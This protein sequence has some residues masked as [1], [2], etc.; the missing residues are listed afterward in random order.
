MK[1]VGTLGDLTSR[2]VTTDQQRPLAADPAVAANSESGSAG[3][4][5]CGTAP[6]FQHAM[7]AWIHSIEFGSAIVT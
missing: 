6:S 1:P 3:G 5:G 4:S 2:I 7:A